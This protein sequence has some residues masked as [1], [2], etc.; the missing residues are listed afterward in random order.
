MTNPN[1]Q[2]TTPDSEEDKKRKYNGM[3][4]VPSGTQEEAYCKASADKYKKP[5]TRPNVSS[6][7]MT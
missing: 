1:I 5:L 4:S 3:D 2:E 6:Y 7:K